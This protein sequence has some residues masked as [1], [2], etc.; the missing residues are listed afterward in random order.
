M[1]D[2]YY[3]TRQ[4][5]GKKEE[6]PTVNHKPNAFLRRTTVERH[7]KR[8][9]DSFAR[10]GGVQERVAVRIYLNDRPVFITELRGTGGIPISS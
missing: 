2:V 1:K 3:W 6:R 7:V 10:F 9:T 5:R 8:F 4:W